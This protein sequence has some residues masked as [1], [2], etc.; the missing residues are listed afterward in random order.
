MWW[1]SCEDLC[2]ESEG[3]LV[4]DR[5]MWA[6]GQACIEHFA[7]CDSDSYELMLVDSK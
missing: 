4:D 5:E 1:A 6:D 7:L 3:Y 2:L